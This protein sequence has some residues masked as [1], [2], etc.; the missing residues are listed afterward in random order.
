MKLPRI[1]PYAYFLVA[2]TSLLIPFPLAHARMVTQIVPTLKVTEE[3][4]DN[5]FQTETDTFEEWKT[6]YELGFSLGFLNQR[7]KIYLEYNPEYTDYK[8]LDDRDGLDHNFNLSG[9][10]QATKHT[11]AM[12]DMNYDGNDGNNTGESWKHSASA[13]VDSQLT[14]TITTSIAYDYSNSYEQQVR[15]GDYKEHQTHSANASI[16]KALGPRNSMGAN[17]SYETDAYQNSDADEYESYEPSAFLTYWFTRRDGVETNLEYQEKK[18]DAPDGNDYETIAGDIRYIRKFAKH[19]DGYA[20]YR[21]YISDR[22]DGDHVIYHPS[23]GVDWDITEDSGISLGIGILFHDWDNNNDDSTDPFLDLNVYKIFNFS[24]KGSLSITASSSYEESDEDAASLGYNT[25]YQAGFSLN[26]KL[27]RRLSS[28]L[29]GSYQLQQFEDTIDRQDDTIE[30]GGGLTWN[31]LKWLQ[32]SA[33]ASH[34]NYKTDDSS[35]DNYKDNTISV[36]VRFAP[37]RPIRPEKI[38]SR[39]TLE[40]KLFD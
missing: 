16:N 4:K 28:Q 23:V 20:K 35:R 19:L 11:S 8:N 37:E 12:I 18:F 30:I 24:P 22:E 3:Y 32:I 17:F 21:H 29:F 7:S 13:S 2:A 25:S 10:W 40:A 1:T 26:Y 14:K 31:P 33:N 27:A 6:S 34:T 38:L 9:T 15:T 36:F 39:K 5:Y